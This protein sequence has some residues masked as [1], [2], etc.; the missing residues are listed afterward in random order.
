MHGFSK[1]GAHLV[2]LDGLALT[3]IDFPKSVKSDEELAGLRLSVGGDRLVVKVART[4]RCVHRTL[5]AM[6]NLKW[7]PGDYGQYAL[8]HDDKRALDCHGGG[9]RLLSTEGPTA[10]ELE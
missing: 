6:L 10:H 9:L 7:T 3:R 4:D 5:S 1:D 8:L 2:V